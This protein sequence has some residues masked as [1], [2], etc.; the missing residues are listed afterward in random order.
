MELEI[1][2]PSEVSK[3]ETNTIWYHLY[4]ESK[5]RHKLT[6]MK[7]KETHRHRE[8]ICGCQEGGK[9]GG[10]LPRNLG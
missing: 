2:M 5:I 6:F 9:V 1:I 7:Q 8:Q 4:V 10:G 3:K